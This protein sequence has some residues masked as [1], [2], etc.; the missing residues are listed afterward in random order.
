MSRQPA[1]ANLPARKAHC[2][3]E[4]RPWGYRAPRLAILSAAIERS[5]LKTPDSN[6]AH[7]RKTTSKKAMCSTQKGI[8]ARPTRSEEALFSARRGE[9]DPKLRELLRKK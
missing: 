7:Q 4:P 8:A 2:L 3:S 9:E 6:T 5:M 1:T